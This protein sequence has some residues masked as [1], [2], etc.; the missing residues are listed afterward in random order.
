LLAGIG[1]WDLWRTVPAEQSAPPE[2]PRIV[3]PVE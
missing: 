2:H 3:R 1:V